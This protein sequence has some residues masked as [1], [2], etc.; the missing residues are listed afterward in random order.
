MPA[1]VG[2]LDDANRAAR[3]AADSDPGA[4][5][6]PEEADDA[7]AAVALLVAVAVALAVGVAREDGD[8]VG[9]TSTT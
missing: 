4:D 1:T 7:V 8:A 3:D 6:A 9:V 5:V 2:W